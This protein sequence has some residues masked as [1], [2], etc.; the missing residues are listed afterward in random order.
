MPFKPYMM[1]ITLEFPWMVGFRYRAFG[2]MAC[3]NMHPVFKVLSWLSDKVQGQSTPE[4]T[5]VRLK[6]V[7]MVFPHVEPF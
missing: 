5:H 2:D 3:H 4:K 7:K 6:V 1:R